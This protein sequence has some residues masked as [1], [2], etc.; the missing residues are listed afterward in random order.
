MDREIGP[1]AGIKL[2]EKIDGNSIKRAKK[3]LLAGE[4]KITRDTLCSGLAIKVNGKSA[5]WYYL[6]RTRNLKIAPLS[7]FGPERIDFLRVLV[8]RA[9]AVESEHGDPSPLLKEA[10]LA[11]TVD[12]AEAKA[13]VKSNQ[14][15]KWETLRN[16]FIKFISANRSSATL[17]TYRSNLGAAKNSQLEADFLP[18][19]GKP[20]SLITSQD[21]L[22]VRN[23]ILER[24][25]NEHGEYVGNVRQANHSLSILKSCFRF[26]FENH[27]SSGLTA[28]PAA[29]V[30]AFTLSKKQKKK[31][32][33]AARGKRRPLTQLELGKILLFL[34]NWPN[35]SMR[36]ATVLQVM[37]G[38]RIESVIAAPKAEMAESYQGAPFELVWKMDSDKAGADRSIPLADYAAKAVKTALELTRS[39]NR[40]LFPQQRPRRKGAMSNGHMSK[41]GANE[42]W[43][44]IRAEGGPLDSCQWNVAGHDL[45]RA[46]VTHMKS[47]WRLH[48]FESKDAT[49]LITHADEGAETTSELI[50]D[51]DEHLQEKWRIIRAWQSFVSTG[52]SYAIEGI[53]EEEAQE[54][55]IEHRLIRERE[56]GIAI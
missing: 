38:Q 22:E 52:Y 21:I 48:N 32:A 19:K 27:K 16:E 36:L 18:L 8:S 40:F 12:E 42:V 6:T 31:L 17:I 1:K 29:P 53:A 9:K 15:W 2:S 34:E 5:A 35:H 13:A 26:G 28:N 30:Q 45:R 10:V 54:R 7:A 56:L 25:K 44:A 50:Y 43:H 11:V 39:D 37:T 47:E 49:D 41:R 51:I 55:Y 3:A 4:M 33:I 20:V 23:N 24:G 46:F 14:A